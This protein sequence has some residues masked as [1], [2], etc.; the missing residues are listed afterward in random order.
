MLSKFYID[1]ENTKSNRTG[2]IYRTELD[3]YPEVDNTNQN[4]PKFT[5]SLKI[6]I[7]DS[8]EHSGS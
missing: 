2:Y 6:P 7:S 5:G 1:F 8:I 4:S 3:N